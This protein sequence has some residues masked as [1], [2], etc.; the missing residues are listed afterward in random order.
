MLDFLKIP[1][2]RAVLDDGTVEDVVLPT[3]L[4]RVD[5]VAY[6]P[7]RHKGKLHCPSCDVKVHFNRGSAVMCG[8]TMQGQRPHFKTNPGNPHDPSCAYI[9]TYDDVEHEEVDR[10]RGYRIHLNL[11]ALSTLFNE[12]ARHYQR[13]DG[14]RIVT[15]DPRLVGRESLAVQS[16]SDL[17]TRLLKNGDP[18]RIRDSVVVQGKHILPWNQFFIRHSS[19]GKDNTR[20]HALTERLLGMNKGARVPVLM[21][22]RADQPAQWNQRGDAGVMDSQKFFW[23]RNDGGAEFIAPRLYLDPPAHGKMAAETAH[24]LQAITSEA[25]AYLVMGFARLHTYQ[26]RTGLLHALNISVSDESQIARV[27]LR[28]LRKKVAAPALAPKPD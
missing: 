12:R 13:A 23:R 19:D 4:A 6:D 21:E 9:V 3:A 26:T 7:D 8:G 2:A 14:R 18:A 10:T 16:A 1:K 27:E 25:G 22:I 17:I 5:A 20:F 24:L 11:A 15:D 28:N